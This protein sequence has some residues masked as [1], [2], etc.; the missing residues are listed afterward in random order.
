MRWPD[1][2]YFTIM[3]T[4]AGKLKQNLLPKA[5]QPAPAKVVCMQGVPGNSDILLEQ[6]LQKYLVFFCY[7]NFT[8]WWLE[9]KMPSDT[10]KQYKDQ[11]NIEESSL[12]STTSSN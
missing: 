9:V 10:L 6:T 12:V 4:S 5:I 1:Y 7:S 2:H 3:A 11:K 8:V